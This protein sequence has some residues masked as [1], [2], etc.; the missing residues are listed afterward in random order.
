MPYPQAMRERAIAAHLE[1]GMKKIEVCRIFG[2]Q[3]R[4]FDEWLRAYEKEGRTYA[5]AKYQQGHSHHVE[6]IE[7]FRLF[8]EEPPLSS[9]SG[10]KSNTKPYAVGC[11]VLDLCIK[12]ESDVYRRRAKSTGSLYP[13]N[14]KA[15]KA[16]GQR[17]LSLHG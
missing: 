1:Q 13:A 16:Y 2:I 6:D 11:I 14:K 12:K 10:V 5:K 7:A 9:A 4:T 3:R 8:L 17:I 15:G